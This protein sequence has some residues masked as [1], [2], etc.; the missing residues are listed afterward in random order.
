[1]RRQNLL[2]PLFAELQGL[3]RLG[4]PALTPSCFLGHQ[5]TVNQSFT[6]FKHGVCG[7]GTYLI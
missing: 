7:A 4:F 2:T 3:F 5:K 1:M 6:K